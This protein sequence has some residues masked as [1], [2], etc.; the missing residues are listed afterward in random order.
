MMVMRT[1]MT[2]VAPSGADETILRVVDTKS[3]LSPNCD[4]CY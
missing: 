4:A 2:V 3:R 1:E